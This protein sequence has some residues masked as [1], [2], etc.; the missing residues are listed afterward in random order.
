[1]KGGV[2]VVSELVR[3]WPTAHISREEED[4]IPLVWFD[5]RNQEFS[6]FFFPSIL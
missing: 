6:S 3:K 1:M 4:A 2:L 5:R